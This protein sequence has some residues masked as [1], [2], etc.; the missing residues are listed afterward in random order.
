MAAFRLPSDVPSRGIH[1]RKTMVCRALLAVGLFCSEPGCTQ[2]INKDPA[3]AKG[4]G[5]Q[6]SSQSGPALDSAD[7]T[8]SVA[9]T[10]TPSGEQGPGTQAPARCFRDDD[11]TDPS[12]PACDLGIQRCVRCTHSQTHCQDPRAPH[13]SV[14][15]GIA[16]CEP[17]TMDAHCG[18]QQPYC[19]RQGPGA[20]SRFQCA[21]CR[22]HSDCVDPAKSRC[23]TRPGVFTCAPCNEVE[24]QCPL[25]QTCLVTEQGKGRCT[26][27]V[28][29]VGG[30]S[31]CSNADGSKALPYCSLPDAL[32]HLDPKVPT[33]FRLPHGDETQ[34]GF[35]LPENVQLSLVGQGIFKP[36]LFVGKGSELSVHRLDMRAG[37]LLSDASRL[38]LDAVEM[39]EGANLVVGAQAQAWVERSVFKS[40]PAVIGLPLIDLQRGMLKMSSSVIAGHRIGSADPA[41]DKLALVRLDQSSTLQLDHVTIVDIDLFTKA[42]MFRCMDPLSRVSVQDSIVLGLEKSSP[43]QCTASQLQANRVLSDMARFVEQ[44]GARWERL[45]WGD[46]F[47]DPFQKDFGLKSGGHPAGDPTWARI[48]SLGQWSPGQTPRDLDGE[49]WKIGQGF[50]GADQAE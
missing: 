21:Q 14:V 37:V 10:T 45:D 25:D 18:A 15:D 2:S 40:D 22:A 46:Y 33:T 4:S 27:K 49:P 50:V 1:S 43:L 23:D 13:C 17:C 7:A 48:K 6:G 47:R 8:S 9:A 32:D 11:C 20:P 26:Q 24:G 12:A 41:G 16:S 38:R 5:T 19:V 3:R 42:P 31:D 35:V 34:M 28:L 36:Q 29:Y 30:S 39:G 44:G